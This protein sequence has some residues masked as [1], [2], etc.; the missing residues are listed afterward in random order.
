AK[1]APQDTQLFTRSLQ[2]L[3]CLLAN[4]PEVRRVEPNQEAIDAIRSAPTTIETAAKAFE[5]YADRPCLG[6]RASE[7][8]ASAATRRLPR[9]RTVSYA[10][11]WRRVEA[12]ASG[13]S[14]EGWVRPGTFVGIC[15]F[16]SIDWAVA[17][18]ACLYLSAVSVP[19]PTNLTASD[20]EHV[21]REAEL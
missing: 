19:L 13:L 6:E 12:L 1:A 17:D 10:D 20:L 21:I 9:Y 3:R 15:G 7:R 11:L 18:F 4:D 5:L 16:G 2:R 14:H 8:D